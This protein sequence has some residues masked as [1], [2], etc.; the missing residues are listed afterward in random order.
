MILKKNIF[1]INI[2]GEG[3]DFEEGDLVGQLDVPSRPNGN[4]ANI[5]YLLFLMWEGGCLIAI[6]NAHL[7]VISHEYLMSTIRV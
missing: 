5:G 7:K 6:V 3:I 4:I 1:W 2:L